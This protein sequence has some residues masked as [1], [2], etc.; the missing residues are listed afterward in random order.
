MAHLLPFGVLVEHRI[1]DVDERLITREKA[2]A[3]GEQVALEP[4][5][6]LVLAESALVNLAVNARDAMPDGGKLRIETGN[7]FIDE[8]YAATQQDVTPGQY[9]MLAVSDTGIG[10]T[11][12]TMTRA[13]EP[14][15]TTKPLGQGTGLGLSQVF[16]L[17]RKS[18]V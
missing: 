9:V 10:M 7:T 16:G 11:A 18:V 1:D 3:A 17:D 5:L 12:E 13:F 2:M 4:A 14:F 8:E 15:F 6:A